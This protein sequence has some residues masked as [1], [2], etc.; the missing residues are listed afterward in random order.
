MF[1][2]VIQ[3]KAKDAEAL[4]AGIERWRTE[5]AP[6]ADGWLGSTAGVTDDGE[7]FALARFESEEA[8][9]RNS[10]RPEQGEWWN[11]F[12]QHLDGEAT[13]TD[14]T[15]TDTFAGG[16]SD[17]AGFVQVIQY[18]TT[19]PQRLREFAHETE[20]A[21]QRMRPDVIGGC[22]VYHGDGDVID[23]LY[24]TSEAEA[25]EA[26]AREPDAEAQS[27]MSEMQQLMSGDVRYLDL[28]SPW[29]ASP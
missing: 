22:T 14:S 29:L 9:R 5:L 18:H 17:D 25:R 7:F 20:A 8:A 11:E 4:R 2:Q 27:M 1:A 26:E 21:M 3:G 23:V 16:G 15:D 19:D 28:R 10:D 13:F 24:F 6:G 12:S